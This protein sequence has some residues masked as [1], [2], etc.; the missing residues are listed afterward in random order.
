MSEIYNLARTIKLMV[1]VVEEYG[2][3]TTYE[4]QWRK[5]YDQ[6]SFNSEVVCR[7]FLV[8]KDGCRVPACVVGVGL[9][10]VSDVDSWD[11]G[12]MT[13]GVAV[14]TGYLA[15]A[16]GV[17]FTSAAAC[18]LAVMQMAQDDGATWGESLRLAME[19]D[20]SNAIDL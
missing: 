17:R 7:N 4:S 1:D 5:V 9:S 6:E 11:D 20:L 14:L 2:P 15:T 18:F 19:R 13:A 10:R 8:N 12:V 3:E 16:L